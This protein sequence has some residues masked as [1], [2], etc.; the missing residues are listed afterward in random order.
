MSERRRREAAGL[1]HLQRMAAAEVG[2]GQGVT[3]RLRQPWHC[4]KTQTWTRSPQAIEVRR[5]EIEW[6]LEK[7]KWRERSGRMEWKGGSGR[8][9]VRGRQWGQRLCSHQ[10]LP[11]AGVVRMCAAAAGMACFEPFQRRR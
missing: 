2:S 7:E 5:H 8:M 9:A 6:T 1:G 3:E 10:Q 11:I 4:M